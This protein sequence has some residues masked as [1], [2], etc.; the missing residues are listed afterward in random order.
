VVGDILRVRYELTRL[1]HEGPV[2]TT[3]AAQDRLHGRDVCVRLIRPPFAA[4]SAF[5]EKIREVVERYAPVRHPGVESLVEVDEDEGSPFLVSELTG[6]MSL[7]E[8]IRKLAPFSVPVAVSTAISLCEALESIHGL[9][10]SHGDVSAEN[11]ASLPDGQVRVQ[12]AG[13]WQAY[14]A[15]PLVAG[16]VLPAMSPYLAPEVS[17]GAMPSPCSDVY[18]SGVLLYELLTGRLPYNADTPVSMA[19]KHAA[20]TVPSVRMYNPAVPPVLDEIVK[21]S[22]AKDPADRYPTA[23]DLL[24]DLRVLQDAL[25]FGRAMTWPITRP[26]PSPPT[27]TMPTTSVSRPE[28]RPERPPRERVERDVP[29]WES[30]LIAIFGTAAAVLVGIWIY[31]NVSKPTLVK[32][33]SLTGLSVSEAT[34]ML[35]PSK[36]DLRIDTRRSSEKIP[37]DHIISSD[38]DAGQ[39]VREHSQ[40][41]VV[42]SSGSQLAQVPDVK[43]N[44]VDQARSILES[45][46]LDLDD[47]YEVRPSKTVESGLIIS[48]IPPSGS[49]IDQTSSVK[50]VVSAGDTGGDESDSGTA[51]ASPETSRYYTLIVRLVKLTNPVA[52]RIDVLDDL[53]TRTVLADHEY[54]PGQTVRLA[55]RGAGKNV[56]FRIYYDGQLVKETKADEVSPAPPSNDDSGGDNGGNNGGNNGGDNGDNGGDGGNTAQ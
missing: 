44:S 4:E 8:R 55:T 50:V 28:T 16:I 48:Q 46:H 10:L 31:F 18:A 15:S 23:G 32:V 1:I 36:L 51:S 41:H 3:Y 54:E 34:E 43:G 6:G 33:P 21:K 27:E 38:P 22:L 45:A 42:L 13:M 30:F 7:G 9:G 37:A 49:K 53:G 14:G 25:R 20:G 26:T 17:A 52:L 47:N 5:I 24:S 11:V 2:F 29:L 39:Q 40:V 35:R 56:K 19:L 12:L